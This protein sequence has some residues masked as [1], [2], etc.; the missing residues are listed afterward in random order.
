MAIQYIGSMISGIAS[1]TKP[2]PSAN[3]K[4]VLFIE[5]DTNKVYQ[6][7]TDS[8]NEVTS[9]AASLSGTTLNSDIV[10]SSL[11]TVDALN[12]GSITSGFTSID[13]GSGTITT[14]GTIT[15]GNLDVTGTTTTI[16][17]TNTTIADRLI[18][19]ANGAGSSTADAGIIVERGSTGD[20]A[21]IAWDES[22]D[23]WT[24][25]TTTA[26]GASTGDLSITAGTLV[27]NLTGNV[28]GNTSGT[29]ATVTTA[30]QGAITS[31]G[32]L[33]TLQVDNL[34]INGNTISSTAGTD[35]LITPLTGQQIVLDG[36]IIIDAGV[37]TGA[38][39]ITSG[40]VIVPDGQ[41]TLGSTAVT[42]TA[43]E[44]N[45][46][47]NVSGLVQADLTKLAAIDATAAEV[48]TLD[49][50]DRGSIIYGNASGATTVLGQ[51]AAATVLTSDGT[52]ISWAAAA[53]GGG[54]SVT[55]EVASGQT[56]TSGMAIGIDSAG[57]AVPFTQTGADYTGLTAYQPDADKYVTHMQIAYDTETDLHVGV[58]TKQTT[59]HVHE[60]ANIYAVAF[61]VGADDVI[62]FGTERTIATN[63]VWY[64]KFKVEYCETKQQFLVAWKADGS[65]IEACLIKPVAG[66]PT[67]VNSSTVFE[68]AALAYTDGLG[69]ADASHSS[70]HRMVLQ[71][72]SN[73]YKP[74]A[75][76]ITLGSW[77]ES[78]GGAHDVTLGTDTELRNTSEYYPQAVCWTHQDNSGN[79]GSQII[80]YFY[81]GL[82]GFDIGSSGGTINTIAF[83]SHS[84]IQNKG[85]G[86][87]IWAG[88]AGEVHLV[89]DNSS[90]SDQVIRY[91][92]NASDNVITEG[93]YA[94]G[95]LS[96][97]S[98]SAGQH[99]VA[100][101]YYGTQD[102]MLAV[103]K[104][105]HNQFNYDYGPPGSRYFHSNTLEFYTLYMWD[106]GDGGNRMYGGGA[107]GGAPGDYDYQET[108]P[109]RVN[110]FQGIYTHAARNEAMST[111]YNP[112]RNRAVVATAYSAFD[113]DVR[114]PLDVPRRGQ[115]LFMIKTN[116][117][118]DDQGT[119]PPFLGFSNES[120]SI[121]AG[122][123]VEVTIAGGTNERQSS[124]TIGASY[125]LDSWGKI[126]P[127][128]P[129][130]ISRVNIAAGIA[131]SATELLV[132]GGNSDHNTKE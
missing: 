63:Q 99:G 91:N 55:L 64:G 71:Y 110:P 13:V 9:N 121:T 43:A 79:S 4:G 74:K 124:L 20:N 1:D 7:D 102:R 54:G 3:E 111:S 62:T 31:L 22:A 37:V 117:G 47:D 128:G 2:T 115:G 95:K 16:D 44:L 46:L 58:Y 81:S 11:T 48:D 60:T 61:S 112:D 65:P 87:M 50:L 15:A 19:L 39:S 73:G 84:A 27:A 75:R 90:A 94:N 70:D 96:L 129:L 52:D 119:I 89:H 40:A 109:I 17:S 72:V 8:W 23:T 14:T 42:S 131:L 86:R 106:G 77:N 98:A 85:P 88:T 107:T 66:S 26:T 30:A 101:V 56:I 45:L 35:L 38:T 93:A 104:R 100:L 6:W 68:P 120:G 25:G 21:V 80:A 57:K 132:D 125:Y 67:T 108:G 123:D 116:T 53:G 32:T 12:A 5:T 51:G 69:I 83:K 28:T 24:L 34:N 10:T 33:T 41:L 126:S 105:N 29:A 36:T 97:G 59:A 114:I 130:P 127:F 122:N 113:T 118:M 18:E 103:Q 92:I 78:H 76:I 49:A 82:Y